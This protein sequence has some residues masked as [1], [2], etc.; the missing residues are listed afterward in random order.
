ME[1]P[2]PVQQHTTAWSAVPAATS[3]AAAS[4]QTAHCGSAPGLRAPYGTT[5][6]PRARSSSTRV[7]A[8]GSSMSEETEIRM[9]RAYSA[10]RPPDD[11]SQVVHVR[12][13]E[14]RQFG[15]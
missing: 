5:S 4:E 8:T 9:S 14:V 1:A 15:G 12:T 13:G 11:G 7:R 3:R 2:V 10:A 6:W